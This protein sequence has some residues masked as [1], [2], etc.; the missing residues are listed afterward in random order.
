MG[1]IKNDVL[2][3]RLRK[4]HGDKYIYA[5]DISDNRDENGKIMVTCPRHGEFW[6][7]VSHHLNGVGCKKCSNERNSIPRF[8]T[9]KF[10]EKLFKLHGNDDYDFSNSIYNGYYN[11]VSFICKKHGK[12]TR[13]ASEL[14]TCKYCCNKCH[15]ESIS[16]RQ[17]SN[18]EEFIS[19]AKK[20]HGDKYDYS[21]VKYVSAKENVIIT[22]KIHGDFMQTP[23]SHLSGRGCNKCSSQR[24]TYM[25]NKER[26]EMFR[27]VHG[28]RYSYCWETYTKNHYPMKMICKKHGEF[29]QKPTKHLIG[30]QCPKCNR[31]KLEDDIESFLN[32]NNID[33]IPQKTFGWLGLQSLDFF[34]PKYSIAIECQGGQHFRQ[35]KFYGGEEGL[36]K[37]KLLDERKLKKCNEH[38]I[39]IL[40]YSNLGIE[41]PY[42]VFEDKEK[43]LEE[44]RKGDS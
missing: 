43:L 17:F 20:K 31:S 14:L 21:K 5:I 34:L 8:T 27:K 25:D 1:R 26:E 3:E 36:K 35:V 32:D 40:Y 2:I 11:D 42:E 7:R 37:R 39:R 41:Y 4:V 15:K 28:D 44:I 30:E 10:K 24:F 13:K 9:D 33:F 18:T 16:S 23:N 22:C 29:W 6:I 19:K 12:I 38:S